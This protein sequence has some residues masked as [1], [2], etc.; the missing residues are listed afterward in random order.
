MTDG[1]RWRPTPL[2]LAL[3]LCA[4]AALTAALVAGRW[5]LVSFAAPLLGVLASIHRQR[6]AP[7][8]SVE[9]AP[10]LLRCFEGERVETVV[11]M[12]ADGVALSIRTPPGMDVVS[13]PDPDGRR[14]VVTLCAQRWGRYPVRARLEIVAPGGL[15]ATTAT[16]DV[17]EVLVFPLVGSAATDLPRTELLDRLG[18]HLTRHPGPGVEYADIRP[19]VPGD[20][21][22]VINWPVSARRGNLHV[23]ERLTDRSLDV[24]VLLDMS[25][26]PPGPA[27]DATL[28]SVEGAVQVVQS[29]LRSSDRA[30]LVRLDGQRLR[31]LAPDI[32]QRQFYRVLDTALGAGAGH[33]ADSGTLAPRAAV[34]PGAVVIAFSTLLDASAGLALTDLVRRGHPV[35][36]VDVLQGCPLPDLD[37]ILQRMWALRRLAMYRDLRVVGVQVVPW[38]EEVP[39]EHAL[40]ALPRAVGVRGGRPR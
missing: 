36:V 26:Q 11:S 34:P 30:G 8:V 18:T 7:E 38:P 24:A 5:Q 6:G 20:Q 3:F 39:L 9:A 1:Y 33:R 17:A 32:G 35:V 37:P 13:V 16:V 31:W 23:T 2:A 14:I 10:A 25:A 27:T 4:A 40:R 12:A 15:L 22:R 28:R 29:V 19:Y 21:L